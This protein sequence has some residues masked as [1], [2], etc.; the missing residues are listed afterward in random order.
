MSNSIGVIFP[1]MKHGVW[2]FDDAATGLHEEPFVSGMPE[3]LDRLVAGVADAHKGF[4]LFFSAEPFPGAQVKLDW[5]KAEYGG[6]WYRT[7]MD[8]EEELG[9]LCPA[10][11]KYFPEA[12]MTIHAQ[13]KAVVL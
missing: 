11:F 1:Y 5:V 13:A 8:G 12:P 9:W 4:A 7:T 2:M 6:N 10:L 3:I